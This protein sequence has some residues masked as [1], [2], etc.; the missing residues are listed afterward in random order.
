MR[1]RDRAASGAQRMVP[2]ASRPA[3][4]S[5]L[6][7]RLLCPRVDPAD[8]AVAVGEAAL[9][10]HRSRSLGSRSRSIS[11]TADALSAGS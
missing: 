2:R 6:V 1:H 5:D 3:P 10:R 7:D 8:I 11:S 4:S 9:A